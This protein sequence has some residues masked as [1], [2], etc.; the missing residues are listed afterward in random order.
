MYIRV[1]PQGFSRT[2]RGTSRREVPYDTRFALQSTRARFALQS[3][4][5]HA[6]KLVPE[7][8][9]ATPTRD[10]EGH[11]GAVCQSQFGSPRARR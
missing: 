7:A 9:S 5:A 4:R 3:T 10:A 2:L 6:T 8:A 11:N 1:R